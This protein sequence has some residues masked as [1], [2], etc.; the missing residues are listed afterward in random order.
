MS[1]A[2][3]AVFLPGNVITDGLGQETRVLE[4]LGKQASFPQSIVIGTQKLKANESKITVFFFY[5]IL[6]FISHF[7]PVLTTVY[8]PTSVYILLRKKT[9]GTTKICWKKLS[10]YW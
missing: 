4:D 8:F 7:E 1:P 10:D 5:S 6:N 2:S 3:L 9:I